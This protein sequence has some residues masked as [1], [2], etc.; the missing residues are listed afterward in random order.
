M[1]QHSEVA[2]AEVKDSSPSSLEL[3]LNDFAVDTMLLFRSLK[4]T[5]RGSRQ[6]VVASKQFSSPSLRSFR[7]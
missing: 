5:A 1:V 6:F 4:R 3:E 2:S 7:S